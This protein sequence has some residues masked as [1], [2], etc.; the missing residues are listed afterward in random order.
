MRFWK[1]PHWYLLMAVTFVVFGT[2][3]YSTVTNQNAISNDYAAY[4]TF[5]AHMKS[6]GTITTPHFIYPLLVVI[7]SVVIPSLSY[8]ALGAGI[9]LL[10]QLLLAHVLWKLFKQVLPAPASD[11]IAI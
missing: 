11:F 7:A 6:S 5:V 1:S 8:P 4:S 2:N 9:V 3:L 10:F